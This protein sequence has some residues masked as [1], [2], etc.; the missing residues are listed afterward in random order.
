MYKKASYGWLRYWD[1]LLLDLINMQIAFRTACAF[2]LSPTVYS[3]R[4]YRNELVMLVFCQ[5]A[6]A[7]FISPYQDILKRSYY[8]EFRESLKHVCAVMLLAVLHLFLTRQTV[9]HSR[10]L[11]TSTAALYLV[12]LYFSRIFRKM[13]S[14]FFC[15]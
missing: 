15:P 8:V 10:L 7:F 13:L 1:F 3:G 14:A 2:C 6:A 9:E 5:I 4:M 12:L 11:F